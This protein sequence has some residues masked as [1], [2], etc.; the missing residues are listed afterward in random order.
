M[1]LAAAVWRKLRLLLVFVCGLLAVSASAQIN[2]QDRL[3]RCANNRARITQI[4]SQ[5]SH[6]FNDEQEARA[7][8]VL[9]RLRSLRN[10]LVSI[11]TERH[12]N[13]DNLNIGLISV[14]EY[15]RIQSRNTQVWGALFHDFTQ[16][17]HTIGVFCYNEDSGCADRVVT[18]VA[19]LIDDSVAARPMRAALERD[20]AASRSNLIALH[21][22]EP[23]AATT[24]GNLAGGPGSGDGSWSGTYV[25]RA[26]TTTFQFTGGGSSLSAT[27][28]GRFSDVH[29]S[30]SISNCTPSADGGFDCTYKYRHEDAQKTGDI[31][32]RMHLTHPDRCTIVEGASEITAVE[33]TSRDGSPATSPSLF[34][35]ARGGNTYDRQGCR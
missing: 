25:S 30:G 13:G 17:A 28:D 7:R 31:S 24:D 27:F 23:G 26:Y 10:Q 4:E 33:L 35:G 2:E 9:V 21:C 15:S 1:A 16:T 20:L 34:V 18:G 8:A 3:N 14:E 29:N 32:G 22:D 5:L 6:T 12:I 19:K 11:E